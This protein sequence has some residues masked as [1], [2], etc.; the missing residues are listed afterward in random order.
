MSA[1]AP[2]LLLGFGAPAN[3]LGLV[4]DVYL[5]T[6]DFTWHGPKVYGLPWPSLSATT[7]FTAATGF[8]ASLRKQVTIAAAACR[9]TSEVSVSWRTT[10][11]TAEN[12]P[13]MDAVQFKTIPGTGS[14]D[15]ILSA[16]GH[17]EIG[18][19]FLLKYSLS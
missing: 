9:P 11:D 1:S 16:P 18:G 8:P 10:P 2:Q 6:E 3:R 4:G 13:E 17:Q 12:D 5:N 19:N 7:H 14:F 15:L